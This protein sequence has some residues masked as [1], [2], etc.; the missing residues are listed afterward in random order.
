MTRAEQESALIKLVTLSVVLETNDVSPTI[1]R[2]GDL[3]MLGSPTV[4]VECR[5]TPCRTATQ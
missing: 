1:G 5:S 3:K 2:K 4:M